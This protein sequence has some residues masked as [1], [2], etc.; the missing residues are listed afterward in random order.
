MLVLSIISL[1]VVPNARLRAQ[2]FSKLF[3]LVADTLDINSVNFFDRAMT[4]KIDPFPYMGL[5]PYME[6]LVPRD[7]YADSTLHY[8]CLR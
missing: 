4:S 7:L 8:G 2:I 6:K 5:L 1:K 3:I